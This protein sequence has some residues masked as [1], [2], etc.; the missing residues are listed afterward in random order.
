[1]SAGGLRSHISRLCRNVSYI[2]RR[3]FSSGRPYFLPSV[4]SERW[5]GRRRASCI[6]RWAGQNPSV[7]KTKEP[8][9]P[10]SYWYST[11]PAR[12]GEAR[13]F[14]QFRAIEQPMNPPLESLRLRL[15]PNRRSLASC[16]S[17]G[18]ARSAEPPSIDFGS[19]FFSP[20][21]LAGIVAVAHYLG[22]CE[23][24]V[25]HFGFGTASAIY[26]NRHYLPPPLE[27]SRR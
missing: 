16:D 15:G 18:N 12:V 11:M 7:S 23:R 26:P 2:L 13:P 24:A 14:V 9:E 21:K 4:S 6:A 1:V 3:V 19:S 20:H 10:R 17:S 27:S 22:C 25:L 8:I 5:G